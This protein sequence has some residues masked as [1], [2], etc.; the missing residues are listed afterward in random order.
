VGHVPYGEAATG[1]PIGTPAPPVSY[2]NKDASL[3][4]PK[5]LVEPEHELGA[6]A[7]S[8][9]T[10]AQSMV[11]IS[12]SGATKVPEHTKPRPGLAY[13]DGASGEGGAGGSP[14]SRHPPPS[15]PSDYRWI[16]MLPPPSTVVGVAVSLSVLLLS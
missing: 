14:K 6:P 16:T 2:D 15:L 12:S 8:V 11:R 3:H 10:C 9:R 5:Q 1:D 13:P 4:R 7:N